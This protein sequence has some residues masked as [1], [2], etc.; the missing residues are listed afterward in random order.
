MKKKSKE[1]LKDSTHMKNH[2]LE[3][4]SNQLFLLQWGAPI[5][6]DRRNVS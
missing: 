2:L 3:E 1:I 4:H 6:T 5:A